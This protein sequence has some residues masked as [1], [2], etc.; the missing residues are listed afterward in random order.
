[1]RK[2]ALILCA[3]LTF[4]VGCSAN[5]ELGEPTPQESPQ[6]M[7]QETYQ[8][9]PQEPSQEPEAAQ[10]PPLEPEEAP[11]ETPQESSQEISQEP[12]LETPQET[13]MPISEQAPHPLTANEGTEEVIALYSSLIEFNDPSID[14]SH[15]DLIPTVF[16]TSAT[17]TNFR[18]I[19]IAFSNDLENFYLYDTGTIYSL[20]FLTHET[21]FAVYGLPWSTIPQRGVS[22]V[23]EDGITR[24]FAVSISGYDGSIVLGEIFNSPS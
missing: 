16:A 22:F 17:V 21:P 15:L 23:D 20:D 6:E 10:E 7:S 13:Q 1:M 2:I 9:I 5:N 24:S 19:E 14:E 4:I 12:P 11:L 8:E 3:L 18:Y